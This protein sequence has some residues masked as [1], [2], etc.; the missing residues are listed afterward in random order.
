VGHKQLSC[1]GPL[2][3]VGAYPLGQIADACRPD[4]IRFEGRVGAVRAVALPN[5]DPVYGTDGPLMRR[6]KSSGSSK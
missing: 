5:A 4:A 6:W 1:V 2:G 3:V